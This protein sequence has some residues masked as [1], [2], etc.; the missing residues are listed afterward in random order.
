MDQATVEKAYEDE[1][2]NPCILECYTFWFLP[3]WLSMI[4]VLPVP[5]TNSLFKP[6]CKYKDRVIVTLFLCVWFAI[7]A[8]IFVLVFYRKQLHTKILEWY[9]T[10]TS[11][12]E[13]YPEANSD[14]AKALIPDGKSYDL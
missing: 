10:S 14:E 2:E 3:T 5:Y 8:F 12:Q 11:R 13:K 4:L 6:T 9:S 1:G 7:A